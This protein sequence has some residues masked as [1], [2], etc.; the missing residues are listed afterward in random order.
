M[1]SIQIYYIIYVILLKCKKIIRETKISIKVK[2]INK[3]AIFQFDPNNIGIGPMR[4]IP[5]FLTD[6][7]LF[8]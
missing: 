4:I 3:T 8:V 1:I 5:P 6:F 2:I 7:R